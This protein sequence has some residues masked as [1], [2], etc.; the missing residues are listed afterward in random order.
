MRSRGWCFTINNY[1]YEDMDN[2]VF[3]CDF[4]R[5]LIV[6][7]EKGKK[8]TDHIQGFVYFNDAK[9]FQRIKK[10][11]PGAHIERAKG[12]VEDNFEYCSKD[13]EYYEYG[14]K[15]LQG[16]IGRDKMEHV[17][18]NPY[19]NIHVY[20][21]YRKVYKELQREEKKNK[22]KIRT[23]KLIPNSERYDFPGAFIDPDIDTY[24]DEEIIILS[25]Y[26]SFKVIDW[27]KGFP[28]RIKRG[29]EV[30]EID[31]D[32]VCITYADGKEFN[33]LIAKYGKYL[34]EDEN[35]YR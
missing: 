33:S 24:L 6:G 32:I 26:H 9:T 34:D 31:P 14:E 21:Q 7:F 4:A 5:Y 3:M 11:I 30:I 22:K 28:P 17:M 13:D 27:V 8:G 19:E 29:Y 16:S 15:P 20:V 23:I 12:S 18:K 25:V 2:L 35:R 1:T 10:Y